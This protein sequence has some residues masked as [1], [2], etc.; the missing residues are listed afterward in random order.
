MIDETKEEWKNKWDILEYIETFDKNGIH[1][2]KKYNMEILQNLEMGGFISIIRNGKINEWEL[3]VEDR[4]LKHFS[5]SNLY[6][7]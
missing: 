6:I 3:I 7:D 1:F 2:T 4:T 5:G